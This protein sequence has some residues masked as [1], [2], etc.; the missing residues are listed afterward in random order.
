MGV[1][2]HTGP[3]VKIYHLNETMMTILARYSNV[4]D[5]PDSPKGG[6]KT[7]FTDYTSNV[8]S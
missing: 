2:N 3:S 6:W 4:W 7:S 8:V 1:G 5:D